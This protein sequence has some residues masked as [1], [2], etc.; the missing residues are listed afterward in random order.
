MK[1]AI[2]YFL[3]FIQTIF[4]ASAQKF[5]LT[6][7]EFWGGPKKGITL[8]DDNHL[9]VAC[10]GAVLQS[11]NEGFSW[12]KTLNTRELYSISGGTDGQV[13][14]GGRGKIFTSQNHGLS[15]DSL[16]IGGDFPILKIIL[17]PSGNAMAIASETTINGYLGTGIWHFNQQSGIWTQRNMGLGGRIACDQLA[18]DRF[19]RCYVTSMDEFRTGQ[20]G[21]FYSDNEGQ[22]WTQAS[23]NFDGQNIV[24][25]TAKVE[26][27]TG[28][29]VSADSLYIS[30]FGS[31]GSALVRLNLVKGLNEISQPNFWKQTLIQ[32]NA[33]SFWMDRLLNN[34]H[35][36]KN[37]DRYTST[38]GSMASLAGTYFKKSG[39]AWHRTSRGLGLDEFGNFS[40][41]HFAEKS[42]RKIFMVQDMDFRVYWADTS[43]TITKIDTHKQEADIQVF[44]NP[45]SSGK[46]W[47]KGKGKEVLHVKWYDAQMRP[48]GSK[49]IE[50]AS[51]FISTSGWK[52]GIYLFFVKGFQKPERV[53]VN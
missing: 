6:T 37:G 13:L 46:I 49:T 42:N 31:S 44:P 23:L 22:T 4:E 3:L 43:Q 38:S 1:T 15:W 25:N 11:T 24:N 47:I 26:Y 48:M 29:S 8:T 30:I 9:L 39:Q 33:N 27:T 34:I 51:E 45:V 14:A 32:A 50:E 7:Y 12:I 35:F 21:L 41:Q 20:A 10:T 18:V 19:G 17:L 5:W 28:L 16:S 53:I 36:A 40:V 52:K 2:F